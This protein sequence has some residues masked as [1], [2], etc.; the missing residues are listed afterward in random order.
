MKIV[1]DPGHGGKDPGAIGPSGF[2]EKDVT[3]KI[4]LRLRD[5]L[6]NNGFTVLMTREKDVALGNTINADLNA[7]SGMA[8]NAKVD[9]FISIH[10][11]S[12]A[13]S[14]AH[15]IETFCYKFN[16]VGEKLAQK[17][18][19]QLISSTGLSNRGVKEGNFSVLRKTNMPAVLVEAG[20]ISNSNEERLLSDDK[21]INIIAE[22][23]AKGICDYTG[24]KYQGDEYMFKDDKNISEW[25]RPHVK[26]VV[27]FGIMNV[28]AEGYFN[29]KEPVTREELAVVA[30]NI[31]RYITGK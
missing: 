14:A 17:I 18:Q 7:R 23:I 24:I 22:A 13:N 3:L 19:E 10:C 12:S 15:G 21:F 5:K 29:P 1:L 8:N 20:F 26:R 16:S 6:T 31:V 25:A 30:S 9:Y 2:K 28:N 27:E 11:N 4:G